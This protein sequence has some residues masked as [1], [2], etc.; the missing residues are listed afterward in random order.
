MKEFF[1]QIRYVNEEPAKCA[2]KKLSSMQRLYRSV[3]LE[4]AFNCPSDRVAVVA[5]QWQVGSRKQAHAQGLS[6]VHRLDL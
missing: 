4:L 1:L 2:G 3:E 5:W 6:S